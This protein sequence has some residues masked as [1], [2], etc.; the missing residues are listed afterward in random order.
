M[1]DYD[2]VL[3]HIEQSLQLKYLIYKKLG[4]YPKTHSII[5]LIKDIIRIYNAKKKNF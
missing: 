1:S 5:R 4:D 3:F 2:L